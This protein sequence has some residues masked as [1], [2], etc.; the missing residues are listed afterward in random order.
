MKNVIQYSQDVVYSEIFTS[1]YII[2]MN[3]FYNRETIG[4]WQIKDDANV[5][6]L[7][8]LKKI[9]N[10]ASIVSPYLVVDYSSQLK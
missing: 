8:L 3:I 6:D 5:C 2:I 4:F 1:Y 7:I 9:E 10:T